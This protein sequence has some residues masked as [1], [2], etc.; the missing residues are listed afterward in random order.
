MKPGYACFIRELQIDLLTL[1]L[2]VLFCSM[3]YVNADDQDGVRRVIRVLQSSAESPDTSPTAVGAARFLRAQDARVLVPLLNA[4]KSQPLPVVNW[5]RS[6]FDEIADRELTAGGGRIDRK[7]LR[8]IADDAKQ[9]GSAR[10]LALDLLD[11]LEPGTKQVFLLLHL[12]DVEF[13]ADAVA[14]TLV[15]ATELKDRGDTQ[16]AVTQLKSAFQAT[17]EPEQ[18]RIVAA[19]LKDLGESVDVVSHL[20][21]VTHWHVIGPFPGRSMQ[22]VTEAFPP[23]VSLDLKAQYDGKLGP[24]SWKTVEQSASDEWLDFKKL[25]AETDDAVAY[26]AAVVMSDGEREVELRAGADDNLQLWLNG[27]RVLSS[28][29]FYQRPRTD[30]HRVKVRLKAGEN[31]LLAKVCEVKLPPGPPSGGP[32]RWQFGLRVVDE[33]GRGIPLAT[34]P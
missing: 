30:R 29:S 25:L 26:A 16:G 12:N 6:V 28:P 20:G 31:T 9:S 15:S 34:K 5:L 7:A 8:L 4:M 1:G 18:V 33:K 21:T 3:C 32:A 27:Q 23:E 2:C 17:I 22:A 24:V 10:R 11:R 13:A 14:E 19:R